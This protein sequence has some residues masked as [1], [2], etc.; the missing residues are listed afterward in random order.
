M[1]FKTKVWNINNSFRTIKLS[2]VTSV[3]TSCGC[4]GAGAGAGAGAG[5]LDSVGGD[6]RVQIWR[7][8]NAAYLVL[9]RDPGL[10]LV[11]SISS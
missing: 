10:L 11:S 9:W 7:Y 5:V 3:P 8:D 6:V 1:C 4:V 2:E